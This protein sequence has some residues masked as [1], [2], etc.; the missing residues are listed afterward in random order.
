MTE[1]E[2]VLFVIAMIVWV[3]GMWYAISH[4]FVG[5]FL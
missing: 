5:V 2:L 1:L 4:H 3:I